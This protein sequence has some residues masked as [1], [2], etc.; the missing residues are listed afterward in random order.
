MFG[1]EGQH[2]GQRFCAE[3]AFRDIRAEVAAVPQRDDVIRV[4]GDAVVS[5]LHVVLIKG[6]VDFAG[7][8]EPA[9]RVRPQVAEVGFALTR[10]VIR[11]DER[12]GGIRFEG[13]VQLDHIAVRVGEGGGAG[14]GG[15]QAQRQQQRKNLGKFHRLNSFDCFRLSRQKRRGTPLFP[16]GHANA[17]VIVVSFFKKWKNR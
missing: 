12:D 16:K 4:H 8:G 14:G 15:N 5:G 7:N 13:I 10:R 6:R 3:R 2:L 1:A 9:Q 17:F 11:A